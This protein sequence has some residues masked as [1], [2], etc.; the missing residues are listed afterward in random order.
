[1]FYSC[2]S[3]TDAKSVLRAGVSEMLVSY[4][5]FRKNKKGFME[6]LDEIN[7]RDG[8]FMVDSGAFSFIHALGSRELKIDEW[9][10][11]IEEYVQ[12]CT[13]N[14]NKLFCV[15]NFD[16]DNIVGREQVEK[17]NEK[18]F[19]PL[20]KLLDVIFVVQRDVNGWYHDSRGL[21]RLKEYLSHYEYVGVNAS[22]KDSVT[23]VTQ[24]A[25]V[26]RS[27]IHGLA[28]T[29]KA[30]L[31][32]PVFSV[33]SSTWLGGQRYGSTYT[34]DGKNFRTIDYKNKHV[35]KKYKG[36]EDVD[37]E[38]VMKDDSR[39]VTYLNA[40]SW[41]GWRDE[42]V[43]RANSRLIT[44]PVAYYESRKKKSPRT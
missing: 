7:S 2:A 5:Y 40:L 25:R 14:H 3:V 15:A 16:I 32:N 8:V 30:T 6:I 34:Y 26:T 11:F 44:K 13:D 12:F 18:Y 10:E 43:K 20:N 23:R 38:K 4:H 19:E 36:F 31:E 21:H 42:F 17:W 9:V 1:M 37:F 41:K 24:S 27:R 22:M 28:W 29:D 33:D 39:E 35:R